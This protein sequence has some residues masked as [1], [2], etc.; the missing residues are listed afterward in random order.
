MS[1]RVTAFPVPVRAAPAPLGLYLRPGHTGHRE[2]GTVLLSGPQKIFGAVIDASGKKL[3]NRLAKHRKHVEDLRIAL[4][5]RAERLPPS[6]FSA[7][8]ATR[9]ARD[10]QG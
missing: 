3:G 4:G 2:L 9:I 6:S 5:A 10:H 1:D 7:Q 8:P